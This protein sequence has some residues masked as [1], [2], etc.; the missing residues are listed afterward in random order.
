MPQLIL[1]PNRKINCI[2]GLGTGFMLGNTE[3]TRHKLGG[4]MLFAS[5]IGIQFMLGQHWNIGYFYFHQSN[6][7][8]YDCNASLNMHQLV[9]SYTF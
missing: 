7:G 1:S 5:K 6:A 8:L 3:F 4:P 2:F 9:F